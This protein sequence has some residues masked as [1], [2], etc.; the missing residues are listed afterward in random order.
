MIS[1][2]HNKSDQS[3]TYTGESLLIR[4]LGYFT[5]IVVFL[6]GIGFITIFESSTVVIG[7]L[8]II[9]SIYKTSRFIRN[10]TFENNLITVQYE[11][12][13]KKQ[14]PYGNIVTLYKNIEGF[15]FVH[16]YVLKF[17]NEKGIEKKVTF[18]CDESEITKLFGFIVSQG[19]DSRRLNSGVV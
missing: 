6:L 10:L 8:L 17:K 13:G 1:E 15:L 9:L 11:F 12:G 3:F 7:S 14:I 18:Y 16:V 2:K 19:V 5:S 4:Y